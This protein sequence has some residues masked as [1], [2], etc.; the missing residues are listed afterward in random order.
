M[1]YYG[2]PNIV[3]GITQ[4]SGVEIHATSNTM[5]MEGVAYVCAT[6]GEATSLR[7]LQRWA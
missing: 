7:S 4:N 5:I 6:D 1:D 3:H 2:Q